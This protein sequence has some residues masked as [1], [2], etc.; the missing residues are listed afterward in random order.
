MD[1]VTGEGK[2]HPKSGSMVDDPHARTA[3]ESGTRNAQ[4]GPSFPGFFA[5]CHDMAGRHKQPGLLSDID[6]RPA[7]VVVVSS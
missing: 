4:S 1:E 6:D 2:E 5:D 7:A 3:M